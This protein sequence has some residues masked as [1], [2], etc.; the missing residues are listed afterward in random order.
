M[1]SDNY[2]ST[3]RRRYQELF[4]REQHRRL[5]PEEL[6]ELR[7]LEKREVAE[8]FCEGVAG[9]M[10]DDL[11]LERALKGVHHGL[12]F[13][14]H[15]EDAADRVSGLKMGLQAVLDE[16]DALMAAVRV[17]LRKLEDDDDAR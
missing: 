13:V 15:A 10:A 4:A 11:N 16:P 7:R 8:W 6:A 5:P 17:L 3:E 14:T 2:T 12:A 9:A 1:T